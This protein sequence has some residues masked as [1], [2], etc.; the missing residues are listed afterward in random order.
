[1][2]TVHCRSAADER[3]SSLHER[4]LFTPNDCVLRPAAVP[5]DKQIQISLNCQPIVV[6]DVPI[7]WHRR[8]FHCRCRADSRVGRCERGVR[9]AAT[10]RTA[11]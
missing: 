7:Q 10:C 3:S 9:T 5:V 8:A 1:M 6:G 11:R 2:L 4:R